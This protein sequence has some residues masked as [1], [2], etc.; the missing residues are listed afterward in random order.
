MI[1]QK[2]MGWEGDADDDVKGEL[3]KLLGGHHLDGDVD[4]GVVDVDVDRLLAGSMD[5]LA[6]SDDDDTGQGAGA[7]PDVGPHGEAQAWMHA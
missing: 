6:L 4:L 2:A 1:G 5:K 3:E 7:D